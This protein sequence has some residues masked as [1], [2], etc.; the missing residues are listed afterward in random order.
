MTT[1][2]CPTRSVW[3]PGQVA[4]VTHH[5]KASVIGQTCKPTPGQHAQTCWLFDGE[6]R[7]PPDQAA[8][9]FA[10]HSETGGKTSIALVIAL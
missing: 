6:S 3:R 8:M 1:A 7:L 10:V 4:A 9:V 2:A 5:Q